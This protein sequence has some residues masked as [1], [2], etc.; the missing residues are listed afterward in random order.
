MTAKNLN[1]RQRFT[2]VMWH[3]TQRWF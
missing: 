2:Y 1:N 3:I